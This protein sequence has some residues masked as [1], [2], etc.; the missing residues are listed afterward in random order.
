MSQARAKPSQRVGQ[1]RPRP[2]NITLPHVEY[3]L[4]RAAVER[5]AYPSDDGCSFDF[6]IAYEGVP[7]VCAQHRHCSRGVAR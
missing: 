1:M 6:V 7:V 4:V 2:K 5:L 3:A